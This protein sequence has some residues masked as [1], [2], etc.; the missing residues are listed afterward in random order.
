ME[1]LLIS[2]WGLAD[3]YTSQRTWH[4]QVTNKTSQAFI[5]FHW[6]HA[7]WWKTPRQIWWC[8]LG[9][10]TVTYRRWQDS[11]IY[12]FC[13]AVLYYTHKQSNNIPC[14]YL[15]RSPRS[16]NK[17]KI[18]SGISHALLRRKKERDLVVINHYVSCDSH[19]KTL[20]LS[21]HINS[22]DSVIISFTDEETD[23]Q[24]EL[25]NQIR[26]HHTSN[27]AREE[28]SHLVSTLVSE[29]MLNLL[30]IYFQITLCYA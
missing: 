26:D 11:S 19:F 25:S 14:S 13:W 12:H 18:R 16:S 7:P 28:S 15:A 23:N 3:A 27:K 9:H 17:L 22:V 5:L 8:R 4:P 10:A 6:L 1:V 20:S 30:H 29:T 21:P 2:G 24:G